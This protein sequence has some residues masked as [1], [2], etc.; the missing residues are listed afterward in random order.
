ME[1]LQ[2]L[3]LIKYEP[4]TLKLI[5]RLSQ[6]R[7]RIF[8]LGTPHHGN[9]GD[10]LIA[11]SELH[12]FK[13]YTQEYMVLDCT[14]NF[15]KAMLAMIRKNI[16]ADDI[17]VISG[18]GWLGTEWRHNEEF[19]RRVIVTFPENR[20]IILPQTAF[21][22]GDES[23]LIQGAEV[24]R[25]HPDLYFC[26]RDY[27]TYELYMSYN[28]VASQKLLY[29][30][31]MA[32]Y[33]TLWKECKMPQNHRTTHIGLC[34]RDDREVLMDENTRSRIIDAVQISDFNFSIIRTNE[35]GRS[36]RQ[37][38][39]NENLLRKLKEISELHLLVTDRLHAMIMAAITDTP[40][41]V[42]DNSTHKVQGVY[43]WIK[44]L[45][46]IKYLDTADGIK[47][48]VNDMMNRK[49]FKRTFDDWDESEYLMKIAE[50]F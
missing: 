27:M 32:L 14:M 46:Y 21:Y 20:I 5:P 17:I 40:C 37:G 48:I 15:S 49:D 23:Y 6:G 31:D 29:M 10:H 3:K 2:I 1:I 44:E 42:F 25:K 39:R 45:D 13:T 30:P 38:H 33:S 4:E 26:A 50:W 9:L 36:I 18:G 19:V 12:F 22:R 11:E 7:K 8:L 47:E 35:T 28:F 41:I 16:K 34:M 24:Y 43:E